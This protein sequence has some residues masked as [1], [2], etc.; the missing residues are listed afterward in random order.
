MSEKTEGMQALTIEL[1]DKLPG[2]PRLRP[3]RAPR[4]QAMDGSVQ[5]SPEEKG[6]PR[7]AMAGNRAAT[8]NW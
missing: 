6:P 3:A 5:Q 4:L 7:A 2:T 8:R 1:P